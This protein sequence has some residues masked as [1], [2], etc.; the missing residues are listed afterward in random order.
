[1]VLLRKLPLK[2]EKMPSDDEEIKYA[3]SIL[4]KHKDRL[5][6]EASRLKDS[7]DLGAFEQSTHP[8]TSLQRTD[9]VQELVGNLNL[10]AKQKENVEALIVGG[11]T[12]LARKWLSR[13]IGTGL[14]SGAGAVLSDYLLRKLK[15]G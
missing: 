2:V 8:D 14:A 15:G 6:E 10:S 3:L 9:N 4:S 11:G 7:F 12:A 1:M 13:H 5:P